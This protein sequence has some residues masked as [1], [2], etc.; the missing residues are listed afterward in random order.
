M[1]KYLTTDRILL[2]FILAAASFL[3]F[4]NIQNLY[5]HF[6]EFSALFRTGYDNFHELIRKGV[7]ETD[8]HPAGVQVFL[9][10]WVEFFGRSMIRFKLPFILMGLG[11]VYM[12]YKVGR[13]WFNPT[14]GLITAL[15][16]CFTQYALTY[17]LFARPYA[18]GLLFSLLLVWFWSKAFLFQKGNQKINLTGYILSGAMCAYD[19]YFALFF[20]ILVGIS[21]LFVIK[22]NQILYYVLSNLAIFILFIPHLNIFFIQFGKG[23]V[24]SW[25]AKPTPAFF[26]EY[27]QYILHFSF[28]MYM[29]AA[30]LLILSIFHF[31]TSSH[32]RKR[33]ILLFSWL[34]ITYLTAYF[35]SIYCS[36]VLQYSVLI[37]TFPFLIMLVYSF[38][39]DLKPLL[40]IVT[41]TVFILIAFYTLIDNRQYFQIMYHSGYKELLSE[42]FDLRAKFGGDLVTVLLNEPHHIQNYYLDEL[43]LQSDYFKDLNDFKDYKQFE[44]YL[45]NLKT[46]YFIIG[47]VGFNKPAYIPMAESY[48]PF[49]ILEKNWFLCDLYVFSKD[50]PGSFKGP[51][52][53]ILFE[54]NKEFTRSDAGP[55]KIGGDM[56]YINLFTMPIDSLISHWNNRIELKLN[57]TS[58]QIVEEAELVCEIS[59]R[60][61]PVAWQTSRF[62]EF[63]GSNHNTT[64]LYQVIQLSN[65]PQINEATDCKVY[66]WN[67]GLEEF[68]LQQFKIQIRDGNPILYGLFEQIPP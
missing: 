13:L 19:H 21:G 45:N 32:S 39:K 16:L 1:K 6:D 63:Y 57:F 64:S 14:V 24:E 29:V 22:K 11:A 38:I 50:E 58:N 59:N 5:V 3:R 52:D 51:A 44:E 55:K 41:A 2:I 25:L 48:F 26:I 47:G 36:A 56:E 37:F 12:S 66:I 49:M 23:G 53:Q 8:T 28:K 27:I 35:Y 34:I 68:E 7:V 31:H 4:Y 65:I 61:K 42:S 43:D 9:N 54:F 67:R 33:Q 15:F 17:T 60:D 18:T 10:Y 62:N 30:G 46:S 20:L 40:K